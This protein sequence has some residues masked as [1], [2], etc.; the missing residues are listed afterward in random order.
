M[1]TPPP[2]LATVPRVRWILA[3]LALVVLAACNSGTSSTAPTTTKQCLT[4]SP[5]AKGTLEL[6]VGGATTAPDDVRGARRWYYSSAQG[7]TWVSGVDP[8][9]GEAD[10]PTL[11]LNAAARSSSDVGVAVASG[12]P[13]FGSASDTDPAAASSRDCAKP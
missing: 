12:A 6:P 5:A 3:G 10:A 2:A 4:I 11:P 8:D 1:R 7:A 13:A 9:T